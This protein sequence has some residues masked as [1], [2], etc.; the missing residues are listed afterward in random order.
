[1]RGLPKGQAE[2]AVGG[3]S[4]AV[5]VISTA[6]RGLAGPTPQVFGDNGLIIAL[7]LRKHLDL[8]ADREANPHEL[9]K[10]GE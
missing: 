7:Q 5:M 1:M 2:P 10:C 4:A 8:G 6:W 9:A 3:A